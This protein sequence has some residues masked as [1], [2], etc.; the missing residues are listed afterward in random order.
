MEKQ[1]KRQRRKLALRVFAIIISVWM[2]VSAVYVVIRINNEKSYIQSN[3]NAS[4]QLVEEDIASS[5]GTGV[6][7]KHLTN[8]LLFNINYV[9]RDGIPVGDIN[10]QIVLCDY[11]SGKRLADTLGKLRVEYGIQTGVESFNVDYGFIDRN[12]LIKSLSKKQL[13][14][15]AFYLNSLPQDGKYYELICTKFYM[16]I[17]GEIVPKEVQIVLTEE[18]N[19]WYA[20]DEPVETFMLNT[21]SESD[22][23]TE[24]L[25]ECSQVCRNVIPQDFLLDSAYTEDIIGK[26]GKKQL[27]IGTVALQLDLF[28]CI[29]YSCDYINYNPNVLGDDVYKNSTKPYILRYARQV[30]VFDSCKADLYS[31]VSVAFLFFL[32]IGVILYVMIWKL[33]KNQLLQEQKR[34]ELTN[35]L[36]HDI[37]TPLFVISGYAQSLKE[38]INNEKKDWFAHRII[39]KTDEVNS[40]V[41]KMLNLGKL[42]S[43]EVKLNLSDFDLY[44][45]TEEVLQDYINFPD[46]KE[47]KVIHSGKNLIKAD[48]ALIKTALENLI[49]NGVKYS[50]PNSTIKISVI[51]KEFSII[52]K[53]DRFTKSDLKQIWQPYVRKDKSRHQEGSGL[54]LSIVKSILDL[55]K[56]KYSAQYKDGEFVFKMSIN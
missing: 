20:Q 5:S 18:E 7:P 15:I 22:F 9:D 40:L 21:E 13:S 36:A 50:A 24:D 1:L 32:V 8:T 27:Q 43:Y 35:A 45:L 12:R 52:N 49:D 25:L 33:I 38:N 28:N 48:R 26:L 19:V 34:I 47:I 54:G 11:N 53:C 31:G 17:Y 37:K 10:S 44:E 55:H 6:S 14:K 3:L 42:S 29:F 41:H 51:G 4:L 30:N 16:D 39:C 2:I 56:A 23:A 46:G